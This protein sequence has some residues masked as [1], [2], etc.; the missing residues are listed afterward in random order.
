MKLSTLIKLID[1][2][3][4]RAEIDA[5]AL[6]DEPAT[7]AEPEKPTEP[8]TPEESPA[9]GELL[10]EIKALRQALNLKNIHND[11]KDSPEKESAE[12]ILIKLLNGKEN[13]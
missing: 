11:E 10:K 1:A 6:E 7:P 5:M 8:E 4:S 9:D 3:Y 12:D 2:G 13:K